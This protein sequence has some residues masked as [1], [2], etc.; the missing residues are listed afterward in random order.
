MKYYLIHG[1][2]TSREK[3]MRDQMYAF[4][5]E[6]E[7]VTWINHPNKDEPMPNGIC[8]NPDLQLGAVSC[9]YKH[10]LALKDIVEKNLELAVIMEDNIGFF[11]IVP[12]CL[13]KYIQDLPQDWD[14]L[15]DSNIC[16]LK[17]I[18]GP[19]FPN[20]S[21]YKKSNDVTEQCHGG[22]RGAN[23]IVVNRR[24]AKVLYDNFLPFFHPSDF[25]Y[26]NLLRTLNLNSYWTEPPNVYKV[27]RPSTAYS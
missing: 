9:T 11:S 2:D 26:N 20:I 5:I 8:T 27:D 14:I 22:S 17:Y 16:S 23:F 10:Y 4:G 24:S 15:F 18:E 6:E 3:F 1:V 12:Y 19:I 25:H 13:E 7:D 21:V